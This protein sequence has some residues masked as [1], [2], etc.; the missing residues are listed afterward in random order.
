MRI[1]NKNGRRPFLQPDNSGMSPRVNARLEHTIATSNLRS[2]ES[3]K[4]DGV[5][6]L[7]WQRT[8]SSESGISGRTCS[9]HGGKRSLPAALL[10]KEI[11][12]TPSGQETDI[13]DTTSA[14]EDDGDYE[15]VGIASDISKGNG[16]LANPLTPRVQTTVQNVNTDLDDEQWENE[17]T[18]DTFDSGV[19]FAVDDNGRDALSDFN[20]L[21][22]FVGGSESMAESGTTG[23]STSTAEGVACPVCAAATYVEAWQPYGGRRIVFSLLDTDDFDTDGELNREAHPNVLSLEEGQFV[24]FTL[25]TPLLFESVIRAALWNGRTPLEAPN[26]TVTFV[27]P[28]TSAVLEATP[29]NIQATSGAGEP[30]RFTFR[31]NSPTLVTHFD[32]IVML[33]DLPLAQMTPMNAPYEFEMLEYMTTMQIECGADIYAAP[34]DVLSDFKFRKCWRVSNVGAKFTAGGGTLP[35]I[36]DLTV[37]TSFSPYFSLHPFTT[38][39]AQG[40]NR[41]SGMNQSLQGKGNFKR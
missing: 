37:L 36:L 26:Y 1:G 17:L 33:R 11:R 24:S 19:K 16:N 21:E 7:L 23:N 5:E 8:P 10:R 28:T 15:I 34:G 2:Q 25:K 3:I 40:E 29:K 12:H 32:L 20:E 18:D 30:L 41:F 31:A 14:D 13:F 39:R 6:I 27:D 38:P 4:V 22:S 35:T 9:C